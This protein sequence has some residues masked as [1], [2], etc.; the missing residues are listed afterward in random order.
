MGST[1]QFVAIDWGTT[2]RRI[3][4][5]GADGEIGE[6][7]ADDR[8]I[9][10]FRQ[11]DFDREIRA[12][13]QQYPVGP[14]VLAG[15]IGSNR[16]WVE[17]AYVPC[18]VRFTDI[19]NALVR[20]ADD[21]MIIPGV[22]MTGDGRC[23][24]M[25]GEEIQILGA[26]CT[27]MIHPDTLV[28]HPGTHAKWAHVRERAILSFR[29]VM[30]GEMFALLRKHSILSDLLKAKVLVGGIFTAGVRHA[31]DHDD[32]LAALFSVRAKALLGNLA[33]EDAASFISGL[34]IGSDVKIGLEGSDPLL[35]VALIGDPQLTSLYAAALAVADRPSEQIDG[36]QA[37]L[38]GV[39][40]ILS[41]LA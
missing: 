32:L 19:A 14:I 31:I 13:R 25:R 12:L 6:R 34:L 36:E 28:C 8:G 4:T 26:A 17:A 20:P 23:D 27:G 40:L 30:T 11:G 1:R 38:A 33:R 9:T 41:E 21:V 16:G 5:I 7:I 15:M 39:K 37:F 3:F 18:P 10:A 35:S 29:T 22:S 2:N 24:V